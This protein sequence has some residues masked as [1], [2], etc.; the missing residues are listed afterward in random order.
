MGVGLDLIRSAN[1]MAAVS[2]WNKRANAWVK[3]VKL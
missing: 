2:Y 1:Q 3:W